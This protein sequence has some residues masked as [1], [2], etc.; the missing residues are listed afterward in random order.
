[1]KKYQEHIGKEGEKILKSAIGKQIQVLWSPGFT[2]DLDHPNIVTNSLSIGLDSKEY[3]II[4]NDWYDTPNNYLDIYTMEVSLSDEPAGIEVTKK[5]SGGN[6]IHY[7]VS[8]LCLGKSSSIAT[9]KVFEII[10][11]LEEESVEFDAGILFIREDNLQFFVTP[12][13]TISGALEIISNITEIESNIES[14]R[15]RVKL[16]A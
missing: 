16:G 7:P 4:D 13:R 2:L 11:E 8:S 6:I 12:E 10:E 3:L 1:M 15:E 14:M 5:E 9:I